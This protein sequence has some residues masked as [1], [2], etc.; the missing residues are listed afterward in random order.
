M[1]TT[2]KGFIVSRAKENPRMMRLATEGGGRTPNI[3]NSLF[4]DMK[5]V[6][7]NI[8]MYVDSKGILNG[9][10]SPKS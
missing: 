4:T 2:Y 8:D 5:T 1:I 9:K 3:L 6:K 10:A 7:E